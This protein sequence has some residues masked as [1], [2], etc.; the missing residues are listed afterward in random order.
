M[1]RR[2]FLH[3]IGHVSALAA[4]FPALSF[5]YLDFTTSS[6]LSN[7]LTSGRSIVIIKLDGGNDGLNTVIPQDY[8]SELNIARPHVVLQDNKILSLGKNDLGLHP[9]LS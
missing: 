1:E 7:T 6:F 3:N 9:S 4:A 8:L 5:K 2:K